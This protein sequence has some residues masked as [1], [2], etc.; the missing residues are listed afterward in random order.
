MAQGVRR[1]L[2]EGRKEKNEDLEKGKNLG[3]ATQP[4]IPLTTSRDVSR[5][6]PPCR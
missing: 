5:D 4:H 6:P 3:K 1:R 2:R